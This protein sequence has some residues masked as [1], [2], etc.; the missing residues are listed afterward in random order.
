[1]NSTGRRGL[2]GCPVFA[3]ANVGRKSRATWISCY[4]AL[5]QR[6]EVQQEIR[7]KPIQRFWSVQGTVVH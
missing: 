6:H 3:L 1:M 7:G 4:A 2:D 5:Y